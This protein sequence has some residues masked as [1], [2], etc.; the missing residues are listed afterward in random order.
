[1]LI[2]QAIVR[3]AIT[4][5]LDPQIHVPRTSTHNS[6]AGIG[7]KEQRKLKKL[8]F[9]IADRD[10]IQDISFPY[11]TTMASPKFACNALGRAFAC[12]VSSLVLD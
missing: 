3:S 8:T 7:K 1:M 4:P 2:L 5:S 6:P 10:F 9:S 12:T 11:N